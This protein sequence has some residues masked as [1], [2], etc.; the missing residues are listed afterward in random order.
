MPAAGASNVR[1][2]A[3]NDEYYPSGDVAVDLDGEPTLVEVVVRDEGDQV[4]Y[5]ASGSPTPTLYQPN[6]ARCDGENYTLSLLATPA[7]G[8][9]QL[10]WPPQGALL[11]ARGRESVVLFTACG[12]DRVQLDETGYTRVGG[13]LG[14]P[15]G[16][17]PGWNSPYQRGW[18]TRSGDEVVYTDDAGHRETFRRDETLSPPAPLRLSTGHPRPGSH[19]DLDGGVAPGPSLGHHG[20]RAL[21]RRGRARSGRHR[22]RPERGGARRRRG[23][24]GRPRAGA[25]RDDRRGLVR[26]RGSP[27]HGLGARA[28]QLRRAPPPPASRGAAGGG[29]SVG[30]DGALDAM[31][32]QYLEHY[33]D[34]WRGFD[35]VEGALADIRT[36]GL[37]TA[38]L[39]NGAEVQQ[40]A[41]LERIALL[42]R[43]GP[44]FTAEALRVGKPSP[45]AFAAVCASLGLAPG[46]VLHVGDD[47]ALDVLAA[48]AAGLRAV[49]LDRTGAGPVDEPARITTLAD[50]GAH[51]DRL[52]QQE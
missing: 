40:R 19:P 4:V 31:F 41:K 26:R 16:P 15:D 38:V 28:G 21:D 50:L 18:A 47:H 1:G 44:V 51:L 5:T 32:E 49:H 46:S 20:G 43:V 13:V 48:R 25:E 24:A 8:L 6:G 42:D 3:G 35:D 14:G 52:D 12:I 33:Q 2:F 22:V 17:P 45:Q 11:D 7:G 30:D 36:R 9:E 34:A 39:T 37:A 23:L 10:P 27:P 29:A